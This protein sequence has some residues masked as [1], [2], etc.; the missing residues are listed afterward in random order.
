MPSGSLRF[1]GLLGGITPFTYLQF[2]GHS[3]VLP[4]HSRLFIVLTELGWHYVELT[5]LESRK[6][7]GLI[8]NQ[9]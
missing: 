1:S 8:R 5:R 2:F 7:R 6:C 3:P 4:S 9:V